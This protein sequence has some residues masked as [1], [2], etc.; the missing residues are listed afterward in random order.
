MYFQLLEMNYVGGE[1]SMLVVLPRKVDGLNGVLKKLADGYDLL[2]D[3]EKNM[4]STKVQVTI[5]KFKI[6]TEI[7]LND[8]LPKVCWFISLLYYMSYKLYFM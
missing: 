2:A 4:Y 5:P 7:D 1:A 3:V 8:L 6:E